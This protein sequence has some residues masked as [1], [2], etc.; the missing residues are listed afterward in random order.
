M[1]EVI[2]TIS[3]LFMFF[4]VAIWRE[5]CERD[6]ATKKLVRDEFRKVNSKNE[7]LESM[8]KAHFGILWTLEDF[9]EWADMH[10]E[11]EYLP[12]PTGEYLHFQSM[13][14]TAPEPQ[15]IFYTKNGEARTHNVSRQGLPLVKYRSKNV[16]P[17]AER[18][19]E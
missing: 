16:I 3:V 11:H 18:K 1:L 7:Y 15:E 2:L 9:A 19:V 4:I 5:I 10:P 14:D 8:L 6:A 12:L 17:R 13:I